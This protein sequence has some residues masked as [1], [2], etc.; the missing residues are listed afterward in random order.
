MQRAVK[1]VRPANA[2]KIAATSWFAVLFCGQLFFALYISILFGANLLLATPENVNESGLMVGY[3]AGD[4]FGNAMLF[5]HV[6]TGAMLSIGGALQFWPVL[7]RHFVNFHRWNGRVF[8]TIGVAGALSGLYMTWFREARLG[9]VSAMG[10]TL[11]GLLIP[12]MAILAFM[13]IRR[14][15]LAQ[16]VRFATHC[17]LLI[18]GVLFFR[19]YLMMWYMVN[20]G[21]LGNTSTLDGPADLFLSYGCYGIPMLLAE[22]Y[23]L[24]KR[25][26]SAWFAWVTAMLIGLGTLLTAAGVVGA[27][28]MMWIPRLF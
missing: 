21:P 23:F 18:N 9:D 1:I 8:L 16:H 26:E 7:R 27:V 3:V 15:A 17:F 6:L 20:Q 4:M 19:L 22:L 2:I 13:A 25:R 12:V 14:N 10:V 11:N 5:F 24:A 28:T